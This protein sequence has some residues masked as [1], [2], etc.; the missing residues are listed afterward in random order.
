MIRRKMRSIVQACRPAL[1]LWKVG[2]HLPARSRWA[3]SVKERAAA[4][5]PP[6]IVKGP[7]AQRPAKRNWGKRNCETRK[8][9]EGGS[10]EKIRSVPE[11]SAFGV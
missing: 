4:I 5:S 10:T 2:N 11:K 8:G 3:T 7:S 1:V 9:K 6:T